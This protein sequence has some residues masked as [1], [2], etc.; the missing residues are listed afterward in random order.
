MCRRVKVCVVPAMISLFLLAICSSADILECLSCHSAPSKINKGSRDVRLSA[1][2]D[3][4]HSRLGCVDCHADLTGTKFPHKPKTQPVSCVKC[5]QRRKDSGTAG[6]VASNDKDFTDDIH[7]TAM[8]SGKPGTP[9]CKTCHGTHG[10]R[11]SSSYK[12]GVSRANITTTCGNCHFDKA[13]AKRHGLKDVSNYKNSVHARIVEKANGVEAAALCTDCHRVHS[14]DPAGKAGSSVDRRHVPYTCSNCHAQALEDYQESIHGLAVARGVESAPVC[15]DCHSEHS[16]ADISSPE[17]SVYPTRVPSLCSKCHENSR[18]QRRL[19]L[20]T[21]RLSSYLDSYHGVANKSGDITAA[22]CASCHGSHRIL[23]SDNPNSATHK[24]N[25]PK[26]CGKCHPGAS[27]NF[28]VGSIHVVPSP[29]RDAI[30]YWVRT[31]YIVF[32]IGLIGL[33]CFYIAL[34]LRARWIGRLPWRKGERRR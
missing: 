30:V 10:I 8:R 26:T 33:F 17:S 18:I 29:Q 28:A 31:F 4:A 22:N 25:L 3:S 32:I 27:R 13:F 19:G 11:P 20:P 21:R 14:S 15:T 12:S 7:V 1:L 9:R 16:I 34:D 23:P 5:H 6:S 24:K 2:D